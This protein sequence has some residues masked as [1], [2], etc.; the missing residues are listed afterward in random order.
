MR[1]MARIEPVDPATAPA[2]VAAALERVRRELPLFV[3]QMA[4]LAHL[5][6]L[7]V[8]LVD[9][10]A[11]LPK[12]SL[13]PRPLVELAIL[14]VSSLN[15]C[16]YCLIHHAVLGARYGLTPVQVHAFRTGG[17]RELPLGDDERLVIEY[18]E[19][20]TRDAN[21]VDDQLFARLRARFSEPQVVELTVR[22][23]L[24]GFF[25]RLNQALRID[26]E[27]DAVAAFAGLPTAGEHS[28]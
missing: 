16:E 1:V 18:A 4:T 20:V 2:A 14:T 11:A 21:R 10:Y 27:P 9:L 15:A 23:A 22:I 13:L 24:C 7:V 17:W 12:E 28:A 6:G 25:N 8:R 19:Q 26:V 5:P 3:N